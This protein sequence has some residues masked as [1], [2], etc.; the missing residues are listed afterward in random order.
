MEGVVVIITGPTCSGKTF[1]GIEL[2]KKMNGEIISADSRQC[3]KYLDIGTAKPS[4]KELD[5]IKHHL[6][7]THQPDQDFNA[8]IFEH[9]SLN[10]IDN[11][12]E[13]DKLPIVVGGSGLY[14]RALTDGIF[15]DVD[16]DEDFRNQ[17]KDLKD[18]HG[19]EYIYQMLMERD[20]QA[21]ETMLPQNWK[22]V[23]RALE[24]LHVTG[25]SIREVQ[26]EYERNL[27]IN[28]LLFGLNWE[29]EILYQRI[30]RR[31]DEMISAGLIE[32]VKSL[33]E[34][35]FTNELNS[36]NTVGYKEIFS[37]LDNEIGI[38][39]AIELIKRNTRR[40][41][42]RQM[43]WFRRDKR[44]EWMKINRES[45]LELVVKRIES[46]LINLDI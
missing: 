12:F 30:N 11:L 35:G 6:I 18:K 45:E 17:M 2:A 46:E 4:P 28:F 37:Y 20:S 1:V 24:V 5:S 3:Y 41:A 36:L 27:N 42:K 8:S 32:E 16:N 13:H 26:N 7:D 19:N 44:I 25:K 39:R 40:F 22:R 33:K 14:I 38:E 21:A 31:V 43:T 15:D 29:R 10:I 34:R 23:I 9:Q